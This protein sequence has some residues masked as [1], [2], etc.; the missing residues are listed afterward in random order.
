MPDAVSTSPMHVETTPKTAWVL[1]GGG[2]LG[3]VQVG[4]LT[5]LI[6]AGEVPDLIVG[7]SAGALNGAFLAHNACVDT[8]ARMAMLWSQITTREVLG[9][10]WRSILGMMGLRDH[11]ASSQG[12]RSLLLRE[13]PYRTFSQSAIPLHL[14]CT[15]LITGEEVVIS[16]GEVIEAVVASTAIP[17]VFPSILHQGRHLVDGAVSVSTPISVAVRLGATRVIVL[18]CGFACA[19]NS[20]PKHPWGR[21]MHAITLIGAR[22]LLRD[23]EYFSNSILVSIAP[24]V[25]P[26]DQ[27]SYDYSNGAKLIA[28]GRESTRA[29]LDNDGLTCRDFPAQLTIHSHQ[30]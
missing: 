8:V 19:S 16:E 10:S 15:D 7:V 22:Q 2:S 28:R 30:R 11:L 27:S 12:L 20:I 24:P 25:C 1:S 9:L 26:L 21:A 17:G 14:V 29:W 6:A 23:F 13:L 3:A 5:E 18:P 4:M